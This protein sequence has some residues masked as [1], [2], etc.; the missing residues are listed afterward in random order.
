M[1]SVE[2]L[3]RRYPAV[4]LVQL[5][6]R[7]GIAAAFNACIRSA[8]GDG[9]VLLNNDT[10]PAPR[11]LEHLEAACGADPHI[12]ACASKILFIK[13]RKTINSAGDFY[14]RDGTP[15][16][17][18][19]WEIDR[20][21]YDQSPHVFS[22]MAAAALYRRAALEDVGLF[23]EGLVSY[24]E[25]IDWSFRAHLRGWHCRFAP[26]AVVYHHGSATGG[27]SYASYRC[28][29]NFVLV[30]VKNM[31]GK[32]FRRY[33]PL[34]VARE[35]WLSLKALPHGR[36]PAAR[37]WLRGQG[38]ALFALPRYLRLR[39]EVQ[40]QR[41]VAEEEIDRLLSGDWHFWR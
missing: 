22:A 3:R 32:L 38:A 23:D 12:G 20:G 25:D 10:E 14:R 11:W 37:A 9:I 2:L 13:D 31:P 29:R 15:G 19:V 7:P 27:G 35:L 21:Q 40:R 4:R 28:G 6:R 26:H 18:G 41:L 1:R 24:C 5:G 16:N 34:H 17:R 30:F 8:R 39:H 33:L 36:E